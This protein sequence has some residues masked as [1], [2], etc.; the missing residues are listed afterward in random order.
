M[1]T[2]KMNNLSKT[3]LN[4]TQLISN[5]KFSS[6][7]QIRHLCH[8]R[9]RLYEEFDSIWIEYNNNKASYNQWNKALDKWLNSELI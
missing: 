7:S 8:M 9:K 4:K 2:L 1:S 6:Q 5:D 3:F